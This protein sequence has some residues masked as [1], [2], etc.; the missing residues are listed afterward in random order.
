M[1]FVVG[2][3]DFRVFG[4]HIDDG[5]Q[6]QAIGQQLQPSV[7]AG[8]VAVWNNHDHIV[9]GLVALGGDRHI[10]NAFNETA[11]DTAVVAVA[12]PDKSLREGEP[13]LGVGKTSKGRRG[14]QTRKRSSSNA[15]STQS[16]PRSASDSCSA[17]GKEVGVQAA[18]ICSTLKESNRR[19]IMH[20]VRI[21]G[22]PFTENL[23]L[24][25]LSIEDSGGMYVE[26][27]ENVNNPID[28]SATQRRRRSAGGVFLY[29]L[30]QR[31]SAVQWKRITEA[32]RRI[33]R[34]RRSK[35]RSRRRNVAREAVTPSL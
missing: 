10:R 27:K 35:I 29:L 13:V 1:R 5:A 23:R 33:K 30:R 25:T 6:G 4:Q 3:F 28:A 22:I 20:A 32:D 12:K 7:C 34:Q 8:H 14:T 15:S 16:R 11:E 26:P 21:M 9:D 24:E 18:K 31:V 19:I 2:L 17:S